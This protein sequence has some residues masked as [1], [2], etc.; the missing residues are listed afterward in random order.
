MSKNGYIYIIQQGKSDYY[1]IGY[2]TKEVTKRLADLQTG[3]PEVLHIV[4]YHHVD[5]RR[6]TERILHEIAGKYHYRGE[7]FFIPKKEV[8][9]F[10]QHYVD[11]KV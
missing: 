9:R 3:N 7:W 4:S 5:D 2:T 11:K 1:K 10:I 6:K 8:I